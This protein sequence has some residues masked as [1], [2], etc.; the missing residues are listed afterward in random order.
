MPSSQP[1]A[2]FLGRLDSIR[3]AA[4]TQACAVDLDFLEFTGSQC[5][6]S[7]YGSQVRRG[8]QRRNH[9]KSVFARKNYFILTCP[10]AIR[11]HSL[12]Y[13]RRQ[14]QSEYQPEDGVTR[15]VGITRAH[16]EEDAGKSLH[17]EFPDQ[18]GIDLN[19]AGTPCS[20]SSPSRHAQRQGSRGYARKI[21]T[22][23]R[24]LDIC[25]GNMQEGSF[26]CD[27]NVSIR[28]STTGRTWHAHRI[29][30]H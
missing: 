2:R 27:A 29:E 7:C 28:P 10:R 21:H 18:T 8:Y 6:G 20:K 19:R 12:N 22:L 24:F 15:V 1:L 11:S 4:N 17:E 23:V 14:G 25:D 30:E 26:R 16:L 9:A 13:H 5:R 3:R